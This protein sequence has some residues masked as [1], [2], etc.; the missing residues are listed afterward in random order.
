MPRKKQD[1]SI[2]TLAKEFDCAAG[3]I[4]KALSNST[5]VSEEFRQ[6]VR[7]RADELGFRPNRPR[8]KTFNICLVQDLEF[9]VTISISGYQ[10]PLMEG[11]F[12]FCKDNG[13]E[14]SLYVDTTAN[15]EKSNL[16]K[17]LLLRN[18]D[19]A[20]IV[21]SSRNRDYF[22]DFERN[23]FPYV[24]IYDGPE[25]RTLKVDNLNA[26][27]LALEHLTGLGHKRVAIARQTARREGGMNRYMGFLRAASAAKLSHKEIIEILP[28]SESAG[29]DWGRE[30]LN[31]WIEQKKPYSG[32]FCLSENVAAG[33]L[34]E[35]VLRGVKIPN[36]MSVLTCD[37]L[38]STK[39]SA[40]PLSVVD[41]PNQTVGQAA[42]GYLLEYLSGNQDVELPRP[43]PISQ[44]IKR[45]ST[46]APAPKFK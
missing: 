33:V 20:I 13:A 3:S 22:A 4:S 6:K 39:H 42:A 37:D 24:C 1:V 43:F 21:G 34:S 30:I 7:A 27:R 41:I 40:P 38:E 17:E 10:I 19:A 35:A 9:D 36:D 15:L 44:I 8:R 26:G 12:G 23:L 25:G 11:I 28:P 18:A 31:N 32:L 45:G 5:E 14:F 2:F 46:A 29:F 16:T